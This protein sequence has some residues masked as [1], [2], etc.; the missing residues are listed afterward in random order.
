VG[1]AGPAAAGLVPSRLG[2]ARVRR[3]SHRSRL[4][5]GRPGTSNVNTG[6]IPGGSGASKGGGIG[7][8]VLAGRPESGGATAAGPGSIRSEA[9]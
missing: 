5:P 1:P 6:T 2:W 8:G 9:T 4:A 7:G 3:A